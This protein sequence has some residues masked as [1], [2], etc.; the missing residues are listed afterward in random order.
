VLL[1]TRQ[2]DFHHPD[3]KPEGSRQHIALPL[4]GL[5]SEAYP[6][7]A[8]DYFKALLA[9]PPAPT[10]PVPDRAAL[11]K[12]FALVDFH[13]LSI[14]L[15]G[16]QL[17]D[18]RI[19]E[20]GQRLADFLTEND[21][22]LMAS[23]K[24][25]LDRLDDQ[26]RQW[27]PKLGVFQGG[28][29]E[30]DL[31]DI[32][33]FS[34]SDWQPIRAQLEQTGL[35]RVEYLSNIT[36]PYLKLHPTLAPMLWIQLLSEDQ[37][38][39]Q[40]RYYKRY[41]QI[42][43][44]L[45]FEDNS[46]P[47]EARTIARREL[48]N[49][50]A[51]VNLAIEAGDEDAVKFGN[52]VNWFL[53]VFGLMQDQERIAARL[54]HIQGSIGSNSWYVALVN[55]GEALLGAGHKEKARV[56]FT[57]VLQELGEVPSYE[58]CVTLE[59]I[60]RCLAAQG[61]ITQAVACY[62]TGIKET[63][64]LEQQDATKRQKGNLLSELGNA[65]MIMGDYNRAR[66]AYENALAI[67]QPLN[68]LRSIAATE[69]QLGTL[70]MKQGN[71]QEAKTRYQTALAT[72]RQLDEP[73]SEA[74][75]WHLLGMVYEVEKQWDTAEECYRKAVQIHEGRGDVAAAAG[76][77]NQLA[78]VSQL[79]GRGK[80]AIDYY[81]KAVEDLRQTQ[82]R[83]NLAKV[84]SNLANLL[85]SQPTPSPDGLTN[86]RQYAEE[87]LTIDQAL[88]PAATEIWKTYD[89]LAQITNKQGQEEQAQAYRQRAR[90][91]KVAFAGNQYEL[92]QHRSLINTVITAVGGDAGMKAELEHQMQSAPSQWANVATAIRL[93]LNGNRDE[94]FLV[95]PLGP[96]ESMII[97]V[98]LRG[99]ADPSTLSAILGDE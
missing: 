19:A 39:L 54:E 41:C 25:S 18:R 95:D 26:V 21:N 70:A 77:L 37:T 32:T 92:R 53:K 82:E 52:N 72:F 84:L 66:M 4:R 10:T 20:V 3:Y 50:L 85:Q 55:K 29:M 86:A 93:I 47:Y 11:V 56:V 73:A 40:T 67:M 42:S 46:N 57:E 36:P 97:S 28:A 59:N 91:A 35:I 6:Q 87:A 15:L 89:L 75:S 49:L 71:L 80:A 23:L 61:Q 9:L 30:P 58:R 38:T 99:I 5:G 13:P 68:A 62:L 27:L 31:L 7:D 33:G 43:G 88:D 60:G 98:I 1:T 24:L 81:K 63:E 45:C 65:L 48:P 79:A 12:L 83:A 2:P 14:G 64:H 96:E 17:K 78:M 94:G 76:T 8:L 44:Y 69:G 16:R 22:P 74:V 34:E 51:A 90:Q